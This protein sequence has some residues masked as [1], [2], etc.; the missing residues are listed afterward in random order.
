MPPAYRMCVGF[1]FAAKSVQNKRVLD[2]AI[3]T[4]PVAEEPVESSQTA[5][6]TEYS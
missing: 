6:K 2:K 3:V 4:E 5:H 1:A